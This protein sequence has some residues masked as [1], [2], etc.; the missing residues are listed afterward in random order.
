VSFQ[1]THAIHVGEMVA[2]AVIDAR[3]AALIPAY[4]N[5]SNVSAEIVAVGLPLDVAVYAVDGASTTIAATTTTNISEAIE[6]KFIFRV[7]DRFQMLNVRT[8]AFKQ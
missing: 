2:S 1:V 4:S 3:P 7:S 6:I 5:V 8:K